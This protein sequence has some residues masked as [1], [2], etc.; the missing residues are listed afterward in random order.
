M[1]NFMENQTSLF[2]ADFGLF[3]GFEN[4]PADDAAV[5]NEGL[6]GKKPE[7]KPEKKAEKK[8]TVKKT[9]T[10]SLK[11]NKPVTV[12]GC[13]WRYVIEGEGEISVADA[14][15]AVFHAGYEEVAI[16]KLTTGGESIIY[17]NPFAATITD[18]DQAVPFKDGRV[19]VVCGMQKAEYVIADFDGMEEKDIS[20]LDLTEKFIE[21]H[22]EFA[23]CALRV[24]D[25]IAIP[26]F[27]NSLGDAEKEAESF[28]V[29]QDGRITEMTGADFHLAF[30]PTD[31]KVKLNLY[32]SQEGV[33]FPSY[34]GNYCSVSVSDFGLESRKMSTVEEKYRLPFTL[35][36]ATFNK[37]V[38]VTAEHFGGKSAVTQEDVL[39]AL[40]RSYKVFG[41]SNR[42]FDFFYDKKNNVLSVAIVSGKK[43]A[44]A[45]VPFPTLFDVIDGVRVEKTKIGTFY[46]MLDEDGE[47]ES[48]DFEFSLPKIPLQVFHNILHYFV[49]KG[50]DEA[51]AVIRYDRLRKVY[52]VYEPD[53]IVTHTSVHYDLRN[54]GKPTEVTVMQI[55]SHNNQPTFWSV[56]DNVDESGMGLFGVVG[57]LCEGEEPQY[58]FRAGLNGAFKDLHI[59]E[60]FE[61]GGAA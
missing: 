26:C 60:L 51:M 50:E 57:N 25:G 38:E 11:L 18:D 54:M 39:A 53:Q 27:E 40:A 20:V 12:V 58:K 9:G 6:A 7:K 45:V 48:V 37:D 17:S 10:S 32:R 22:H 8:Q 29:W 2:D 3:D 61:M 23:G 33:V 56:D 16:A 35:T 19:T 34:I 59:S 1:S 30:D 5:L 36:L 47:V 42:K 21:T 49:D 31:K 43:G 13:G 44:A 52:N 55:H 46:G 4:A 24:E 15:K 41:Q 14:A 28:K